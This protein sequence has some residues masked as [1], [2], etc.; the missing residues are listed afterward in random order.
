M[1][2]SCAIKVIAPSSFCNTLTGTNTCNWNEKQSGW[3]V[4]EEANP[5][6][7]GTIT[8]DALQKWLAAMSTPEFQAAVHTRGKAA[9]LAGKA[10]AVQGKAGAEKGAPEV[11]AGAAP[12]V[13]D[14]LAQ[15]LANLYHLV[16]G[17]SCVVC[18][19]GVTNIL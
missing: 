3:Y 16:R 1:R 17:C 19:V 8:L 14:K 10:G 11:P 12:S 6:V 4:Q 2:P 5:E 15:F 18:G 7:A 9:K 13:A